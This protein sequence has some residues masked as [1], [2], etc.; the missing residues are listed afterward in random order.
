LA[1]AQ[2][3]RKPIFRKTRVKA[4]DRITSSSCANLA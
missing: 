3:A 4:V 2:R 1:E